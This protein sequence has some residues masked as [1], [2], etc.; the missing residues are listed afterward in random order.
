MKIT[1]KDFRDQD[2][3]ACIASYEKQKRKQELKSLSLC[4]II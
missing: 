2:L 3:R 1:K 4:T